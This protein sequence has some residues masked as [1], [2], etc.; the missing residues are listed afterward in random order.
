M[1]TLAL[2][3]L[4][5]HLENGESIPFSPDM[6]PGEFLGNAGGLFDDEFVRQAAHAV[7]HF[8]KRE[9]GR[10]SVSF[11]EFAEALEKALQGF[12]GGGGPAPSA[13]PGPSDLDLG[14]LAR[15]SGEGLELFFFPRLR[16]ELRQQLGSAPRVMRFRGLRGCVKQLAGARRWS[17]RCRA[18]EERIVVFLRECLDAEHA[19]GELAM[20]VE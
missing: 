14:R 16:E 12:K 11:A 13:S 6:L 10:Q 3:C 9:Q 7:F 17:G 5:F 2:D 4:L 15:E 1:I 20:V 19:Q 8:F 18:L